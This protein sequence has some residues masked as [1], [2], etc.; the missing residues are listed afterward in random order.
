[1]TIDERSEGRRLLWVLRTKVME[2]VGLRKPSIEGQN[3]I[4]LAVES[5]E[6]VCPMGDRCYE[7][8]RNLL[9]YHAEHL[10]ALLGKDDATMEALRI[11]ADALEK[12]LEMEAAA[13][14]DH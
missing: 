10:D 2:Y 3:A 1:M 6:A 13:D 9:R 5:I 4:K 11:G 8:A 7:R 14:A 12:R